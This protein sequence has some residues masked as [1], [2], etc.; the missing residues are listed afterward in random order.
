[1]SP[2]RAFVVKKN[3]SEVNNFGE[4]ELKKK[5]KWLTFIVWKF[6]NNSVQ[7]N[8]KKKRIEHNQNI[9]YSKLKANP[10]NFVTC[11]FM[12]FSWE[13]KS[14]R[15]KMNR[16]KLN[17]KSS[18]MSPRIP[19][20]RPFHRQWLPGR[21]HD[22]RGPLGHQ[23]DHLWYY[24]KRCSWSRRSRPGVNGQTLKM[25][26]KWHRRQLLRGNT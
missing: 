3:N 15:E 26:Q 23:L 1:M 5:F 25:S 8:C 12:N 14:V 6:K 21:T 9:A 20:Q 19:Y 16:Q 11:Q 2:P 4:S 7:Q 22:C 24:P 10:W 17:S 18:K 13:K